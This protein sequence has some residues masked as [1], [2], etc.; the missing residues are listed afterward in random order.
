[1]PPNT[2]SGKRLRIK[3]HGIRPANQPP[4]D[5][6]AEIQIALPDNL[7]ADERQQLADISN[8]YSQSPRAE[9]RW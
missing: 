1:V 4:G 7:S 8:R 2:S 6:F 3:G 9:L 5:L